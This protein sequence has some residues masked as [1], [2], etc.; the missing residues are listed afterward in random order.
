MLKKNDHPYVELARTTIY[1]YTLSGQVKGLSDPR[2]EIFNRKAGVFVSIKKD[3]K[4]RGCIGTIKP[5]RENLALEIINNAINAAGKDPRFSPI[6]PT[7]LQEL[8]ISIDVLGPAEEIKGIEELDPVKY[9]VIVEKGYSRGLLLPNLAGVD[10]AEAQVEI[11]RQKAGISP[12]EGI[13]L[14]R[15]QVDRYK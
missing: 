1:E 7:E 4:L 5:T 10:T 2:P 14:Y 11:A 3:G 15:F 13:R 12:G 9:G 6:Q 8:E